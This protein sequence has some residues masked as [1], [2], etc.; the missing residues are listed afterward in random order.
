MFC[1][2]TDFVKTLLNFIVG[3]SI[4]DPTTSKDVSSANLT[5]Y[6]CNYF[7]KFYTVLKIIHRKFPTIVIK[8]RYIS[9]HTKYL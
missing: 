6:F 3:L 7:P 5:T 9:G 1:P 8:N 2:T 4:L